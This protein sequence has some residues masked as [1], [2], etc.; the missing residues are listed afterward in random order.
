MGERTTGHASRGATSL[1]GPSWSNIFL[2]G[3]Q[4]N[5]DDIIKDTS[6]GLL[7]THL[8][9]HSPDMIT[10]EYSRGASG[11]WI[12][13]GEIIHPVE[14]ITIAGDMVNMMKQI[15]QVGADL[16]TRSSLQSPTIR[17]AELQISGT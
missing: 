17:F 6:R 11:F 14:E 12:E 16:D 13:N 7:V 10:G 1:P 5:L 2:K 4:G 8:L 3:G 15:D 9:G